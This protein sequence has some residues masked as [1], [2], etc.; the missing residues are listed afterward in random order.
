MSVHIAF[1]FIYA[2]PL[3][4]YISSDDDDV[5]LDQDDK[6]MNQKQ[7]LTKLLLGDNNILDVLSCSVDTGDPYMLNEQNPFRKDICVKCLAGYMVIILCN[8]NM[9]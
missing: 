7:L 9:N 2:V 1:V 4:T 3:F 8:G 6:I 5:L